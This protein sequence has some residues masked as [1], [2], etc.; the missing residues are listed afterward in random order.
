MTLTPDGHCRVQHLP[1]DSI[2][3]MLEHFRQEPIPLEQTGTAGP[4]DAS[5]QLDSRTA[6]STPPAP[7]TLSAYVVNTQ[8]TG[9]QTRLVLCRG[10]IRASVSTVGR[11]AAAA[12][13]TVAG[14]RAVQN[15]YII[16]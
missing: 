5:L 11:A 10:S 16:M 3:E 2:V 6:T 7:V 4:P 9:S 12:V 13:A 15:Q 8:L 14:G 1:F